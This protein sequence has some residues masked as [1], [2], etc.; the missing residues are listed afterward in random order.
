L[1]PDFIFI[2]L[3]CVALTKF[4]LLPGGGV[5]ASEGFEK[6][7]IVNNAR[8]ATNPLYFMGSLSH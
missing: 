3:T 2:A 7:K 6:A 4:Q 8:E 5:E 1:I